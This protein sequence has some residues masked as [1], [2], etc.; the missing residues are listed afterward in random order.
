MPRNMSEARKKHRKVT[1]RSAKRSLLYTVSENGRVS[2]VVDRKSEL[3]WKM[4]ILFLRA[5]LRKGLKYPSGMR[6]MEAFLKKG[7]IKLPEV[8]EEV[9][10]WMS[11]KWAEGKVEHT[12]EVGGGI[13][14]F[15]DLLQ[16]F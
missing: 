8:E 16:N 7:A 1:S 14:S 2:V 6:E 5:L 9:N 15:K 11:K 3:V 12:L 10:R 13:C 4:S